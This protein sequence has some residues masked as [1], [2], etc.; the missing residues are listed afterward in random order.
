MSIITGGAIKTP[1]QQELAQVPQKQPAGTFQAEQ[2]KD[3]IEVKTSQVNY[4]NN[5]KH[6]INARIGEDY[7]PD[8]P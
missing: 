6:T 2:L 4:K 5:P 3:M 1:V 7:E 8:K